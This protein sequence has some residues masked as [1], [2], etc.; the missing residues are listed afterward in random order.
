[1]EI[2]LAILK[3]IIDSLGATVVLPILIFIF[4]LIMGTKP[5]KVF[6]AGVTIGVA[7]I[8]ITLVIGLMRGTLSNAAQAMVTNWDIQRDIVDVGWPSAAAIAFGTDVGLWIIPISF[9]VNFI[10]L[11]LRVTKTLNIDIWNFWH[12]A[13]VG[14]IV[15]IFI[16]FYALLVYVS[17][18]KYLFVLHKIFTSLDLIM[19]RE[20]KEVLLRKVNKSEHKKISWDQLRRQ[21]WFPL[22]AAPGKLFF[23]L[24]K[25]NS[26]Y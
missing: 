18:R 21:I 3:S 8:G 17:Q 4:A 23:R 25:I 16:L 19:K 12:F 9:L 26:S 7:F 11:G 2:F 10:L 22:I 14:S 20:G 6:R 13:F 24:C 5:G 15:N 1:M